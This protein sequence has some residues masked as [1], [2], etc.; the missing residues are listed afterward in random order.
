ME[1]FPAFR[2]T[3]TK[4]HNNNSL[5]T[6][7]VFLR[8]ICARMHTFQQARTLK[9]I[10]Y[11]YRQMYSNLRGFKRV[12]FECQKETQSFSNIGAKPWDQRLDEIKKLGI[13]SFVLQRTFFPKL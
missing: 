2:V 7:F 3:R 11:T 4:L 5:M 8:Y 10:S 9:C 1:N 13:A 6:K 12:R